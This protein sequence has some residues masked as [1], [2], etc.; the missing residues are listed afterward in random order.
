MKRSEMLKKFE[1]WIYDDFDYESFGDIRFSVTQEAILEF[2]EEAGMLPP[3]SEG[4][5]YGLWEKEDEE[6]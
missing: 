6:K 2:F 5:Q 3:E 4:F 1:D